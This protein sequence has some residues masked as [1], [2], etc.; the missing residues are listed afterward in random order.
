MHVSTCSSGVNWGR[1]MYA[2]TMCRLLN[3][4]ELINQ[5]DNMQHSF[6]LE[7][8]RYVHIILK[9]ALSRESPSK[10]LRHALKNLESLVEDD[11]KSIMVFVNPC[12]RV[13]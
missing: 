4:M 13:C 10:D 9:Y 8:D 2:C 1:V 11:G 3:E 7:W 5:T 12:A 6:E